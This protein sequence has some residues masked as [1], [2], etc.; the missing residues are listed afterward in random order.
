MTPKGSEPTTFQLVV[1]YCN[2][3]HHQE[4]L[5][6]HWHLIKYLV[7]ISKVKLFL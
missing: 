5:V 7:T 3:M 2:Q 6:I 4:P 1:Q